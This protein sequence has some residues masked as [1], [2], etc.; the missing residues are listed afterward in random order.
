MRVNIKSIQHRNF[1]EMIKSYRLSF[2]VQNE[3]DNWICVMGLREV[4]EICE[5][6]R[7]NGSI[8]MEYSLFE[9]ERLR[10]NGFEIELM[11]SEECKPL[12]NTIVTVYIK[13]DDKKIDKI[14]KFRNATGLG[15]KESKD[16]IDEMWRYNKPVKLKW[17]NGDIVKKLRDYGFTVQGYVDECFKGQE[18]LF[19]I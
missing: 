8:D 13:D 19:E 12:M 7:D 4:K 10:S 11:D 14:K 18:D 9:I 16:I 6:I 2:L 5:R 3:E 15:L 17:S 1:I